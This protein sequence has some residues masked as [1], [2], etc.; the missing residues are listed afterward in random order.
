MRHGCK[1]SFEYE[2]ERPGHDI[3]EVLVQVEATISDYYPAVNYLRNGDPGY[4]AEGG[5]VEDLKVFL[6]GG[7]ELTPI[8]DDLYNIL[9]VRAM[10][11]AV[12]ECYEEEEPRDE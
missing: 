5:E 7:T 9:A 2:W 12:D 3:G 8:P 1:V 6:P 4:P 10:D 11:C